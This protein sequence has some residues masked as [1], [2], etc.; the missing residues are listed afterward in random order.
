MQAAV[1]KRFLTAEEFAGMFGV[2]LQR[3]Y[4]ILRRNPEITVK[5]GERQ[6][7]VDSTKLESWVQKGGARSAA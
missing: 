7:R 2:S 5:L 4:D 6:V 1:A 3:A